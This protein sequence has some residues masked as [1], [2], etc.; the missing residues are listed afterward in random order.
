MNRTFKVML[1]PAHLPILGFL[2]CAYMMYSL[3]GAT[4]VV[5]GGRMVVGLVFYF[6]TASP[7]PTGHG[8][9]REVIHPQCD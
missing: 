4:W 8:H 3:P 1:F 7:L 9:S 5:F 6:R 2:L